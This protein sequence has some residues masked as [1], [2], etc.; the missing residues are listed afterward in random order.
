MSWAG[1]HGYRAAPVLAAILV[2]SSPGQGAAQ[3]SDAGQP[4][5]TDRPVRVDRD[6]QEFERIGPA[7]APEKAQSPTERFS[8]G[9]SARSRVKV[10]DSVSFTA[11]GIAYRL[12]DLEPVA[13]SRICRNADGTRWACGLRARASLSSLLGS[14]SVRCAPEGKTED[15]E[16]VECRRLGRDLGEAQARGGHALASVGGRY[17]DTEA[18]A[19]AASEGIWADTEDRADPNSAPVAD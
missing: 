16:M 9:F 13:S 7:P 12:V 8:L 11:N 5:W 10:L 6:N 18:A 2:L 19:K 15:F 4:V 3:S 14:Q 1:R 17:A